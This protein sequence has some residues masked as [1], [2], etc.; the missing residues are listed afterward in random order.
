MK[1]WVVIFSVIL[2]L[3]GVGVGY[4]ALRPMPPEHI[5]EKIANNLKDELSLLEGEAKNLLQRLPEQD[6]LALLSS[7]PYP[8]FQY[9]KTGLMSWSDNSFVLP[10]SLLNDEFS[11]RL[12]RTS[13][14]EFL[15]KKWP[16]DS[17]RFLV[18]LITLHRKY[19]IQNNYLQPQWNTRIFPHANTAI[20]DT[21]APAGIPVCIENEC[22]FKVSFEQ[23]RITSQGAAQ[24]GAML[25]I[26]T[27]IFLLIAY[28]YKVLSATKSISRDVTFVLLFLALC[29]IRFL[30]IRFN[31]PALFVRGSLFDPSHFASSNINPSLGDL[32]L[33]ELTLF[34]L[35]YYFFQNYYR[36]KSIQRIYSHH[37]G[38]MLL[39]V[40]SALCLFFSILYPFIVIQ[41]VYNNSA[42]VFDISQTII[43]DGIRTAALFGLLLAWGCSFVFAHVFVRLT[44]SGLPLKKILFSFLAGGLIFIAINELTGQVYWQAVLVTVI[45]FSLVYGLKLS[46][47]LRK[48]RYPTFVYLFAG[49]LCFALIGTLAIQ[50]FARK[51]KIESQFRFASNF[52]IDRD[53]F[54]EYL[55]KDMAKKVAGDVFIQT[56]LA[57]PFLSKDAVRQKIRQVFLSNYFNKYDVNILM[58]SSTGH[59]LENGSSSTFAELVTSYNE[60]GAVQT[61]DDVYFVNS[62]ASDISHRYLVIIPVLKSKIVSGYIVLELLLKKVIPEN[63]YPELLMDSRFAEFNRAEDHSYALFT[64]RGL[65]VSSGDFNYDRFFKREWL[66]DPDMH[67][68]GVRYAGY[69]H[70]AVEDDSGRV[71]VVSS[72]EMSFTYRMANFSFL[73]VSGLALLLVLILIQGL[74]SY[75]KGNTLFFSARI[76]LFVNLAFFLPLIVVSITTLS[77]TSNSSLQQLTQEY[78][79]KSRFF[80]G[81]VA[82]MLDEYNRVNQENRTDLENHLSDLAQLSNL[83]ANVYAPTGKLIATSQSLIFDSDLISTYVNPE[84]LYRVN[85]GENLFVTEERVGKLNYYVSYAALKS[86]QSGHVIGILGIPFFQSERSLEKI[87]I[88]IFANM[89]NV[90][91]GFFII[92]L[93]LSYVGSHWLTF[94][95]R[96]ITRSLSR[97]SLTKINQPLTWRANDEIGL[98]VREYNQMLYKLSESKVELE[99]TQRELAWREIAQQVAHEI[100]NPLTP[101]KLTLQQLERSLHT[102]EEAKEK[103]RKALSSLLDQIDTLDQI[104]SSFSSFAKMPDPD[105]KRLELN[106]LIK[107]IV[108]LHSQSGAINFTSAVKEAYVKADEQLLG[109]IFSNLI[110]NAFQA[111]RPDVPAYVE[112]T[113]EQYEGMFR[114]TFRDNG[115]GINKEL[116]DR[117]FIPHFSTKKSGSGLGLAI[118]KQGIEFMRGRIWFE[119]VYGNGTTFFV[120]LP[121]S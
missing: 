92:L 91:A 80:G 102:G 112:V 15:V 46:R 73:L 96:F 75:L 65:V 50:H 51:E 25:L 72:P 54:G 104:A 32:L 27:S 101:M 84:A 99:Q 98:M 118:S 95:L 63:V 38:R 49:I 117:I 40:F 88:N 16:V 82:A 7:H 66:G 39:S 18:S 71:A 19:N 30:M 3:A 103:T 114:I 2:L 29:G 85:H 13:Q 37:A 17:A 47:S 116:A 107:R 100:K 11:L 45:F 120:E 90:F 86:S 52:L 89:L 43:F 110:L 78:L 113:L 70:I 26:F 93:V 42:I 106:R 35:C 41:T 10:A 9:N 20:Y 87:Q 24:W 5:A 94:P 48:L 76:Q 68:R 8:F 119:S 55:L 61:E 64:H 108:T 36:F 74:A 21:N 121:V 23:G 44:I 57:S 22:I 59:P 33:N 34:V 4:H 81:Q 62:P 12:L 105:I 56:R 60:M 53:D 109:R 67:L 6:T 1:F 111:S 28:I 14:G 115:K 79:N 83:D 77:L 97:T 58:F 31:F 69:D